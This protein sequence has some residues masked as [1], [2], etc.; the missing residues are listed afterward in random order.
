MATV[1]AT[2]TDISD[3]LGQRYDD[4]TDDALT[5]AILEESAAYIRARLA[6]VYT[7]DPTVD[8]S[9]DEPMIARM[10]IDET[11]FTL[12][13][14]RLSSDEVAPGTAIGDMKSDLETM[15]DK[16][17]AREATLNLSD[18]SVAPWVDPDA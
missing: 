11:M 4:I 12:C 10:T 1:W 2:T 7:L 3:R 8:Y 18:E 13:R 9:S 6:G 17:I 16:L 15:L 14:Y 5:A